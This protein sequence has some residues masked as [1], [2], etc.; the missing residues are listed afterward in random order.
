MS[1]A[2]APPAPTTALLTAEEFAARPDPGYPEE[3]VRG[4][5][6][7]MTVPDRR[8]GQICSE[9]VWLLRSFT[10]EHDLGHVL[11]NDSGVITERGP[12]SVRGAD[13]AFYSYQRLPRGPLPKTY[14]PE[15]PELVVEVRSKSDRW[16]R[17]LAKVAEYLVA[18]VS[19]VVVLDD[20]TETA[21]LYT[22]DQH[23]IL[24][25]EA[26]LTLAEILPGFS[27]VV[28]RFFA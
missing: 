14:G 13:V 16:P 8:H 6:V 7:P 20:E 15:V 22:P 17:V 27:V 1:T 26:E 3:L 23:R 4:K 2:Q 21:H 28:Q 18:G 10:Q 11:C 5:I 24:A 9:V 25:P 12:D 19:V